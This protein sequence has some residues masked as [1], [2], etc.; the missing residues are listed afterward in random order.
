LDIPRIGEESLVNRDILLS[1]IE[2][3]V[4][5]FLRDYE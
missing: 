5:T 3:K 1:N 4:S 2:K